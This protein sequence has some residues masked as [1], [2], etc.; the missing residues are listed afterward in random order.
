MYIKTGRPWLVADFFFVVCK[1]KYSRL[2]FDQSVWKSETKHFLGGSMNKTSPHPTPF[3]L[4]SIILAFTR[5][6]LRYVFIFI[7]TTTII[8]LLVE[9]IAHCV[10]SLL[11]TGITY[12]LVRSDGAGKEH[13]L[14]VFCKLNRTEAHHVSLFFNLRLIIPAASSNI[15]CSS[16]FYVSGKYVFISRF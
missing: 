11:R 12:L 13:Y 5:D 9:T 10:T 2:N 1:K 4:T 16:H 6:S 15:K 7:S 3:K 14:A 8:L